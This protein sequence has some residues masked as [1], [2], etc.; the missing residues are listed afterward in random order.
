MKY[1][2]NCG[3]QLKVEAKFCPNCGKPVK[4]PQAQPQ[5][6]PLGQSKP[7]TQSQPQL[8][9]YHQLNRA[10]KTHEPNDWEKMLQVYDVNPKRWLLDEFKVENGVLTVSNLKGIVLTAP[11]DELKIRIQSDNYERREVFVRHNKEKLT[12]KEMPGMLTEDEWRELFDILNTFPNVGETAAGKILKIL[13]VIMAVVGA[14][15][16]IY[17]KYLNNMRTTH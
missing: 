11:I 15:A 16:A 17:I 14:L 5:K 8:Q 2:P 12:F 3:A 4:S 1:C 10:F 13:G 6:Q 7:L 9:P